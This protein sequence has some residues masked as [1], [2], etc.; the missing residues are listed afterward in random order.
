ML[1]HAGCIE[2]T[3][4]LQWCDQARDCMLCRSGVRQLHPRMLVSGLLSKGVRAGQMKKFAH[5][6]FRQ[7][8]LLA[9][10]ANMLCEC[11][12]RDIS[13]RHGQRLLCDIGLPWR[14]PV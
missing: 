6:Q 3:G 8:Y 12:S 10:N 14:Y 4:L 2:R 13:D 11:D 7:C 9:C 1:W 5:T